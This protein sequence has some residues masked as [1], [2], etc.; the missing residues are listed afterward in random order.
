MALSA[1]GYKVYVVER[2]P[3]IGGHAREGPMPGGQVRN[4][5]TMLFMRVVDKNS[6]VS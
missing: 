2:N 3:H 6:D 4:P 5:G 1:F